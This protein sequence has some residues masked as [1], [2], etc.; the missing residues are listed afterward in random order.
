MTKPV[1]MLDS[2]LLNG[3]G[4][5][6]KLIS[7]Q[8]EKTPKDEFHPP[9]FLFKQKSFDLFSVLLPSKILSHT[10]ILNIN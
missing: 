4:C 5:L 10:A 2:A 1:I 3:G 8:E 6:V 7:K 9:A